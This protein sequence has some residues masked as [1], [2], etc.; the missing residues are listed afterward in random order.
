MGRDSKVTSALKRSTWG[1]A[2]PRFSK[3]R[4]R[5]ARAASATGEPPTG[6]STRS[7]TRRASQAAA[8]AISSS[9]PEGRTS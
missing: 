4:K 8:R 7:V 9:S 5:A 2:S 3:A 6:V 1:S